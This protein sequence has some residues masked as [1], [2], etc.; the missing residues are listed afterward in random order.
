MRALA[1]LLLFVPGLAAAE[2]P[3]EIASDYRQEHGAQILGD[4]AELLRVPNVATDSVN[5]RRNAVLLTELFRERGA[6]MEMLQLEGAVPLVTGRVNTPGATRTLGIYV[7]YDGQPV[8]ETRWPQSPWEP[9]IYTQDLDRGGKPRAFPA[10]GEEID[11]EWRLY[12]R[13]AGD[14]KAPFPALLN[15]LDALGEA[16]VALTSNL[17]FLFE[18]EEESG[19]EHLGDYLEEFRHKFEADVWLICDGPMHQSRKPQLV[20]G[21]R[22]F[23][24]MEITVYGASRALHSGHYGNWSPNPAMMLAQLLAGMKDDDGNVEIIGF[25]ESSEP[26]GESERQALATIPD[27]DAALMRGLDLARTEGG[28]ASLSDQI[29]KP[30]LNIRGLASGNVGD[31]ARNVIPKTATASIDI[32]LVKGNDPETM[33]DLVEEHIQRQ[34]Y[35]IVREDPDRMTRRTQP[36]IAKVT[37]ATSGY[38]AARTEMDH[39]IVPLLAEAARQASG[40]EDVILTPGMGGSLPLYLFND[41]LER[42]VVIVPIANH[43]DNQHAPNENL[44][45][46]NLWYGID[47]MAAV[48]TMP[49]EAIDGGE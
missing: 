32:R 4:Y 10:A 37:R 9:T 12:A 33:L 8:D 31:L 13:A 7:H 34:G 48:L 11:P 2:T 44:R 24:S 36:R 20:F 45:I 26:I 29:L 21:V 14:D 27:I 1:L 47:L 22:G 17:V 49:A 5:L 25:Y 35:F 18:G 46:A 42:P 43:D 19:S 41:I 39:P 3:V 15:A 16:G 28:G 6:E 38:V 30:S 23:T 40:G